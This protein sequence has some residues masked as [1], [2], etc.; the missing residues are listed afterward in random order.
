MT[1]RQ[2]VTTNSAVVETPADAGALAMSGKTNPAVP[3]ARDI[4]VFNRLEVDL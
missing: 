2:V 4:R 3:A 1:L